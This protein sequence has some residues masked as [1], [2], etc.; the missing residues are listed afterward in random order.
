M[1]IPVS[2]LAVRDNVPAGCN[3]LVL[4]SLAYMLRSSGA[5]PEPIRVRPIEACGMWRVMDGRHRFLAAVVAGRS[6]VFCEIDTDE[7]AP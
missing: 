6:D 7:V 4:M 2:A 5:D 3:P 1:R